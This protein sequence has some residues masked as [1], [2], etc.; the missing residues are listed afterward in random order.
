M[1]T[2]TVK[3]KDIESKD[4]RKMLKTEKHHKHEI[5]KDRNGVLRWKEVDGVNKLVDKI[6][7]N[8]LVMLLHTLG[9]NQN[10]EMYRK[11]Y[12]SMGYS[13][14]GYWEVFYWEVNNPIAHKYKPGRDC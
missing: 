11:L 10:S 14:F 6:G 12:R 1:K 9:Y 4:L 8:E 2:K 7:L 3:I 5:V 13:L